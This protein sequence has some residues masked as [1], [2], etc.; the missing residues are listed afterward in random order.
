M[1]K[2]CKQNVNLTWYNQKEAGCEK[3]LIK[4]LIYL[5]PIQAETLVR[6]EPYEMLSHEPRFDIFQVITKF[7]IHCSFIS[8]IFDHSKN[9][10]SYVSTLFFTFNGKEIIY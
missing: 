3:F 5:K 8:F 10:T 1:H 2:L 9:Y 6:L 4:W 7:V